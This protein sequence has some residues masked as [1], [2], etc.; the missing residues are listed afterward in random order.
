MPGALV[1]DVASI[2]APVVAAAI[3]AGL[4]DRFAGSHP[5][6]GTHLAGWSGARPDRFSGAIVYVCATGAAGDHVAREIMNFWAGVM[7]AHPVLMDAAVHDAQL[8][9]T[10]H[11]PQAV[12][13]A[14][15]RAL[16]R[17][18]AARGASFGSGMRDTTRLAASPVEMWVDILLMNRGSV[19]DALA[20]VEGELATLRSLLEADDRPGL[21]AFL[22]EAAL[23]RR[24]LERDERHTDRGAGPV[25]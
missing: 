2:K 11:L 18:P 12:A 10:S 20:G 14:L 16:A 24:R 7:R 15:A 9:W 6:T 21:Y 1:T 3:E 22:E 8:A 23:F 5:F 13:S 4:A 25:R 19:R 17:A